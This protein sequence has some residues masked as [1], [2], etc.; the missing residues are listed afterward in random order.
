MFNQLIE[1]TNARKKTSRPP[2]TGF[3]PVYKT[4]LLNRAQ[5]ADLA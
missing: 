1:S 5:T 2:G 4:T 3:E